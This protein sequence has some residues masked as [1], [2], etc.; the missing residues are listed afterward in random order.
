MK[1]QACSTSP[2]DHEKKMV[3]K[4]SP[5]CE[6][7][8]LK[9]GPWTREED[10]ILISFIHQF[11]HP[12]WRALPKQAAKLPG[13]T[14]NEIKNY[15]HTRLKKRP[16]Y[17]VTTIQQQHCSNETVILQKDI[18]HATM[19]PIPE[20]FTT[21]QRIIQCPGHHIQQQVS[22]QQFR[23]ELPDSMEM[24]ATGQVGVE[25]ST[26]TDVSPGK[27][28]VARDNN[29]AVMEDAMKYDK[30]SNDMEFWYN[31]FMKAGKFT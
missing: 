1:E 3:R 8:G 4:M 2:D 21:R 31:V 23:L 13:R 22:Q 19:L 9:K 10:Q 18:N 6:K 15:W 12:N 5:C 25:G 26:V 27:V 30:Y 24:I 14:D 17:L 29:V 16:N 28:S 20:N 7:M 11:G